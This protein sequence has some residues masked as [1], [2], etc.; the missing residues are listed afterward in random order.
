M[1]VMS[2]YVSKQ[3][4]IKL[5]LAFSWLLAVTT[6]APVYADE[7]PD[8]TVKT[9]TDKMLAVIKAGKQSYKKTPD[10]FY[11]QLLEVLE[12]VV[13][14]DVIARGVMSIK[15]SKNASDKQVVQFTEAFKM[16]MVEFYGKALLKYDNE[17][18]EVHPVNK[19]TLKKK[20]VPV[21]MTIHA[22][23]GVTYPLTYT[24]FKD[25]KV[26]QWK[27][28]NVIVNG[29]NIGKLFRTQFSEAMQQ[30]KGDLQQ[31]INNWT[32]IMKAANEK[33]KS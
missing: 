21:N 12:P 29:I 4:L 19:A 32:D 26:D 22:A 3:W 15:Y 23:D 25:K 6:L 33:G 11:S 27:M 5:V 31:V 18:I 8:A 24:M 20:R 14:F 1:K 7:S 10:K 13:A 9:A 2:Q 17:K 28:R 16:S 30:N